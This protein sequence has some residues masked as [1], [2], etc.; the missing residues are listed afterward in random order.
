MNLFASDAF[1]PMVSARLKWDSVVAVACADSWLRGTRRQVNELRDEQGFR[2]PLRDDLWVNV[3]PPRSGGPWRIESESIGPA[4]VGRG[5]TDDKAF[6]DWR[7]R[8]QATIERF[9]ELR[10]FEMTDED[11]ELWKRLQTVIDVPRYRARK[12]IVFRQAGKISKKRTGVLTVKWEDG[13]YEKVN[14][15]HF[16]EAFSKYAVGQWFEA[17]VSRHPVTY[18]IMRAD[19]VRR[20]SKLTPVSK[21]KAAALW[22]CVVGNS[23]TKESTEIDE[24]FWLGSE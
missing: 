13:G 1:F 7:K 16:D 19:A 21:E 4:V 10:P 3:F 20:L 18:G 9:L 24:N 2:Y 11:Q 8:M 15:M 5:T 17:M 22:Q 12:P 23:E 14:P 6:Q